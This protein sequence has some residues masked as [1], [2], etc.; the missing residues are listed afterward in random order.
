[1]E[2]NPERSTPNKQIARAHARPIMALA[3]DGSMLISA[4]IFSHRK[5]L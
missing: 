4:E 2:A 1:L 3:V 5:R